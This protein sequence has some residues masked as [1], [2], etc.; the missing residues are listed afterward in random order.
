[1]VRPLMRRIPLIAAQLAAGAHL[2]AGAALA[3]EHGAEHAESV[4]QQLLWPS[5]NFLIYIAILRF[6]IV[7]FVNPALRARS[8][9]V[10]GQLQKA[11]SDIAGA[12]SDLGVREERRRGIAAE[13][14]LIRE[15]LEQEGQRVAEEIVRNGAL[16]AEQARADVQKKVE[17]ELK[18]ATTE[19]RELVVEGAAKRAREIL[20]TSLSRDDDKRLRQEAING[21]FE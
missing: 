12:K 2:L 10:E 11:A 6:C 14:K 8:A 1:M 21:L 13:Q 19:V 5:L 7:R 18:R 3:A 16:A 20:R 17:Q 9:E 15:R 4:G